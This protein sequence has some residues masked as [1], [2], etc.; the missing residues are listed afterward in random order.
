MKG[1]VEEL[2]NFIICSDDYDFLPVSRRQFRLENKVAKLDEEKRQFLYEV[3]SEWER[4]GFRNGFAYA[5][6]LMK[7]CHI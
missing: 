7:E 3:M 2:Y 5:V 4:Y 1:L 6:H